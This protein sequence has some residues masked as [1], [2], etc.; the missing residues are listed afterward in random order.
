MSTY[1]RPRLLG[2]VV[3]LLLLALDVSEET[4][5]A[6]YLRSAVFGQN[7]R[8]R[9]GLNEQIETVFGFLP[10]DAFV[11]LLIGV[12]ADLLD[13]ALTSVRREWGSVDAYFQAAGIDAELMDRYREAM[14]V[15]L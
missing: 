11:D 9:G 12:E 3:A 4:V 5:M 2:A 14:V 15:A 10:D 6:D 7:L 1:P 13:A 8:E